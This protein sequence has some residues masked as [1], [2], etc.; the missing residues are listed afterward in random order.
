MQEAGAKDNSR[1]GQMANQTPQPGGIPEQEH[2]HQDLSTNRVAEGAQP[3]NPDTSTTERGENF[4][5]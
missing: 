1:T 4:D 3:S 2:I 5:L